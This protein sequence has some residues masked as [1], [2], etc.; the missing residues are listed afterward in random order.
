L[1]ERSKFLQENN[2]DHYARPYFE[3]GSLWRTSLYVTLTHKLINYY[4]CNTYPLTESV[5]MCV[6]Q[7]FYQFKPRGVTLAVSKLTLAKLT[8]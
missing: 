5:C 8:L 3:V 2:P 6:F 4:M 7:R 1:D